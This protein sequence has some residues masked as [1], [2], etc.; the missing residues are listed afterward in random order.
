MI[1]RRFR[2]DAV[3]CGRQIFTE[4]FA[5]GVLAPSAHHHLCLPSILEIPDSSDAGD[6]TQIQWNAIDS[7]H[8]RSW[9]KTL[10][11]QFRLALATA[12]QERGYAIDLLDDDDWRWSIR[13]VP[14][15]VCRFFSAR[16]ATI[17]EELSNAGVTST[18]A[19]ALAA[20]IT[21]RSRREKSAGGDLTQQ[22]RDA[23]EQLGYEPDAIVQTAKAAGRAANRELSAERR[24]QLIRA[25][26]E[27]VP[28]NL[29]RNQATFERRH[30]LEA[31]AN[32]L[33]GTKATPDRVHEEAKQLLAARTI[34]TLGETRDGPVHSTPEMVAIE[35]G[36]VATATR[37]AAD[38]V[39]GPD[40]GLV[41]RLAAQEGLSAEQVAVAQA[42]TSGARLV[43]VLGI[44][45]SGKSAALRVVAQAWA[46]K[47]FRVCAGSVT[48]RA[49]R[50]LGRQLGVESRAID[51]WLARAEA[52]QP[53][54]DSRTVVL[55]DEAA[56]QSS[57]QSARLLSYIERSG[58]L[59][60]CAGDNSQLLPVGPG[61]AMRLIREAIGAV[62]L[63]A[64]IRQRAPWAR[65]MVHAFA[66]GDA[67]AGL[68]E[69]KLKFVLHGEKLQGG[70]MLVR[71]SRPPG[72]KN[73]WLLFKERDKFA[74]DQDDP[75]I[76]EKE[77]RSVTTGRDL[78]Q[79]ATGKSRVWQSNGK[80]AKPKARRT[81][82]SPASSKR[83]KAP[84]RTQKVQMATL[85]QRAPDGAEWLH[86]I[87]LDGYR[88]LC[89]I[90]A[91]QVNFISRNAQDWTRKFPQLAQAAAS[92][93]LDNAL[94]DGEVVR[95]DS[96]GRSSF[97]GMQNAFREGRDR[98]L[99][100]FAFDLLFLNGEDLREQPLEQRKE[101]LTELLK[102][103]GKKSSI[104]LSEH[105]DGSGPK[106]FDE[107]CKLGL[108][109]IV[110]K[111]R[112]GP[113]REGRGL[114]WLKTKCSARDEFVI[115][116]FTDP[117]GARSGLGALLLGYHAGPL[118][119]YA[120]K[121]GTGFTEQTL[122]DLFKTLKP[123]EQ[124]ESSFDNLTKRAR[125]VHWVRPKLVAE[126]AYSNWTDDGRLRQ[127]VFQGLRADKPA[128]QVVRDRPI[129]T[130][131]ANAVSKNPARRGGKIAVEVGGVAIS[132]PDR[133]VYPEQGITKLQL[134]QYYETVAEW[135]L[136]HVVDR[137]LVLV[138]CPEGIGGDCFYQKH[139]GPG[140]PKS[141][142]QIAVKEKSQTL[143]YAVAHDAKDLISLAQ[144]GVLELHVWGSHTDEI[145]KPDRLVFDLDP[146]PSV[147]WT[148]LVKCT[149]QVRQFLEDLGLRTFLK[150]TGGKGLHL[151]APIQ[152]RH[153]WPEVREFCE[154]V[155]RAIVTAEPDR[156]TANMSK[157][158]RTGKIFV[159]YL[160]NARGA[161][162]V[163][164]YSTRARAGAT[165]AT[166]ISWDELTAKLSPV[167][168]NVETVPQRLA[169]L[170]HD[171]WA[172]IGEVRQSITATMKRKLSSS[173]S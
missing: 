69:G 15:E 24:R 152:R 100:Y 160:R 23:T 38:R 66:R 60:V 20:A 17:E 49:A 148:D 139:S 29:V 114:D 154:A 142:G 134:A 63:Q 3:L 67:K 128:R 78:A 106:F 127:P 68:R 43:A 27:P 126:I 9:K 33:V 158:A 153:E 40:P 107:C 110:S 28:G 39:D 163:A 98:D 120:G 2:C 109:G 79:I 26:L 13:G 104:R 7:V 76:L 52:G 151:V 21:L 10:G 155:A 147:T 121:V 141:L 156:Y 77:D 81:R 135:M 18:A 58:G 72:S 96:D 132:H 86:E 108:E 93:P 84:P 161:T 36:L 167:Q 123:L 173:A 115:G 55:I 171:P 112:D 146:D 88:M 144:F 31:V 45:G 71:T 14:S 166:P 140:L 92:L 73:S 75:D 150:T 83:T 168:F 137:P 136:P 44:A 19:P 46:S 70:W 162:A 62:T 16:R 56:L 119:H 164:P 124:A 113:Y 122:R 172:E 74:R 53:V 30:L 4:R 34:L 145:E 42:A 50:T 170:K 80:G 64:I 1:A 105:I 82:K 25:R 87:K 12:L 94:L 65:D 59:A 35:R 37:L 91:G 133:V 85:S 48:W 51:S 111:R 97:Q 103:R 22:W 130:K 125:G 99:T 57:P 165:V 11:A 41:A 5:E 102:P 32:A 138:R 8:I 61:H 159:D 131:K 54:F 157:K 101:R 90:E 47:G 95:L 6:K 149:R 129:D 118:L 89:R 116:G 169:R 117:S 143:R